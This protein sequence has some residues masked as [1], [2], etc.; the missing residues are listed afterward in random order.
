MP[1]H[2]RFEADT[3]EDFLEGGCELL[4]GP[5]VVS[6]QG[7]IWLARRGLGPRQSRDTPLPSVAG[8]QGFV[9]GCCGLSSLPGMR[10]V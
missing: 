3:Q 10:G 4:D 6:F 1:Q 2:E 5:G 8:P 9:L 7:S